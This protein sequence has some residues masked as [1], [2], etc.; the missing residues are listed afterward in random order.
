MLADL[1]D[2]QSLGLRVTQLTFF[3]GDLTEC[4]Q[5]QAFKVIFMEALESS[6]IKIAVEYS[7]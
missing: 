4:Y 5:A 7:E 6:R 3:V 1:K 2:Y